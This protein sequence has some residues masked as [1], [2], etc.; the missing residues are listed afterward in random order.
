M[1]C[2]SFPRCTRT[3]RQLM[4]CGPSV[5][6]VSGTFLARVVVGWQT[7]KA[8]VKLDGHI[9]DH[10][11]LGAVNVRISK[12]ISGGLIGEVSVLPHVGQFPQQ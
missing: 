3:P 6:T 10:S 11:A 7:G 9:Q 12:W 5:E 8:L 2:R 1:A 4:R